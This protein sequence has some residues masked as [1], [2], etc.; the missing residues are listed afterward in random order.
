MTRWQ[1][2][3]FWVIGF[4]ASIISTEALRC[5][6]HET[7]NIWVVLQK[8]NMELLSRNRFFNF[9]LVMLHF[10]HGIKCLLYK[11]FRTLSKPSSLWEC[12]IARNMSHMLCDA[13][14]I[15]H[16]RVTSTNPWYLCW[17]FPSLIDD[18]VSYVVILPYMYMGHVMLH[19]V[20][21]FRNH[22]T[23]TM[24]LLCFQF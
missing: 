14:Y 2:R 13:L 3:V 20:F 17:I 6:S 19:L 21:S 12:E 23:Y 5:G 8:N 9:I 24:W 15:M 22:G 10:L 16:Q 1:V 4:N 11:P 18:T 7:Q